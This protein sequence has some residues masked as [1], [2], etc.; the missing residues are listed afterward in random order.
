MTW[1][2]RLLT[3]IIFNYVRARVAKKAAAI[4]VAKAKEWQKKRSAAK[5]K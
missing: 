3:P 4:A 1:L 2:A 5:I